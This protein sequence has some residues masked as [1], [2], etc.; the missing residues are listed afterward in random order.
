MHDFDIYAE[1]M[2]TDSQKLHVNIKLRHKV[3][4]DEPDGGRNSEA[5]TSINLFATNFYDYTGRPAKYA[6]RYYRNKQ[7]MLAKVSA[8]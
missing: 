3:S 5:W 4:E 2:T 8:C 7:S 1:W 6:T